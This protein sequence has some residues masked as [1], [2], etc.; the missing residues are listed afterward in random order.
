MKLSR[1]ERFDLAYKLRVLGKLYP[2]SLGTFESEIEALESGYMLHYEGAYELIS[3][4]E[5]SIKE[6]EFVLEVL[7]LYRSLI[8]SFEKIDNPKNLK[9]EDLRF[10]GF[11]GNNETK[12]WR[13]T[14]YYIERC[15]SPS[16]HFNEIRLL[17]N[18]NKKDNLGY[19]NSHEPMIDDY[20]KMLEKFY[21][22]SKK[23]K[24]ELTEEQIIEVLK[25]YS[26][27]LSDG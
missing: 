18:G 23:Y 21:T 4:E 1:K 6:C 14:E 15:N 13:Y 10:P 17:C 22:F 2:N 26:P 20:K 27:S 12:H 25:I 8:F 24:C 7:N 3:T 5:L 16:Y 11:D 9:K 19:Y